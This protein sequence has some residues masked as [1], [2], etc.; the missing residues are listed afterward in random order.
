MS[1]LSYISHIVLQ[2]TFFYNFIINK[3]SSAIFTY[4]DLLSRFDIKLSL[5]R[6][7]VETTAAGIS[8]DRNN[9]Q[10]VSCI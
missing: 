9:C 2:M 5:G 10:S 4:D 1:R 7:L 6:D 3:N 8:L